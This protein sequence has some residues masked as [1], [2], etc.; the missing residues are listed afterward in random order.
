[1]ETYER[2]IL[3]EE[4]ERALQDMWD[5]ETWQSACEILVERANR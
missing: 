5:N 1:V 4:A 3:R 2:E